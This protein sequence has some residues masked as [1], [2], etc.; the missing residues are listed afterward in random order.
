MQPC[1][2]SEP[3][4]PRPRATPPLSDGHRDGSL[5]IIRRSHGQCRRQCTQSVALR[6]APP[7]GPASVQVRLSDRGGHGV[8]VTDSVRLPAGGPAVTRTSRA[9][10][11]LEPPAPGPPRPR[12]SRR[13]VRVRVAAG[14]VT[15]GVTSHGDSGYPSPSESS[16]CPGRPGRNCGGQCSDG[17]SRRAWAGGSP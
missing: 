8:T 11:R 17:P 12:A 13:R 4:G 5:E 3:A 14:N 9:L 16:R 10:A 2:D 1:S 15:A 6:L 7:A